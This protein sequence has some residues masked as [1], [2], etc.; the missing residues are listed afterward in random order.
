MSEQEEGL[1]F[2][3]RNIDTW[4]PLIEAG[5]EAIVVTASG[6]GAMVKEYG[7]ALKYDSD[8]ADKAAKVSALAKDPCEVVVSENL[9]SLKLRPSNKKI[10]FQTPCT[11][12]H[13]Q[14]LDGRIE[15]ILRQLGFELSSVADGH[16][17][18]GSAGTYSLLQAEMSQSLLENKLNALM[19]DKPDIIATANIGCHMHLESKANVPVKHWLELIAEAME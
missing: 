15:P 18:C 9:S 1:N 7:D 19:S 16:L 8:Y 4:W 3:R 5:I 11:L 2:M 13:A 17:C 12:Q 10:A 6:C 14:H